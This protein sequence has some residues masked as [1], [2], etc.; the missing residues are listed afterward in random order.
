MNPINTPPYPGA[1]RTIQMWAG[2][3]GASD[4]VSDANPSLD[5]VANLTGLDT[6]V[7][8]YTKC[9]SGGAVELWT[10]NGGSHIPSLSSQFAPKVIDWLLAHPKP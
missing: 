1:I 3:N 5:L 9:R 2:Y 6:V 8:R 7:T 4:P 10:I